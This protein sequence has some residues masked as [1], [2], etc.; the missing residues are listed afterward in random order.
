MIYGLNN[1]LGDGHS[2]HVVEGNGGEDGCGEDKPTSPIKQ[3]G[4]P[5]R[6]VLINQGDQGEAVSHTKLVRGKRKAKV[7][8]GECRN[9]GAKGSSK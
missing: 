8:L 4:A 5:P 6:Q 7:S 2:R 1:S 3:G 9:R